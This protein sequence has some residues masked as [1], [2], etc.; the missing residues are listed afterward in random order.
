[1]SEDKTPIQPKKLPI[2]TGPAIAPE[3]YSNNHNWL[4]KPLLR[5]PKRPIVTPPK[6]KQSNA[7]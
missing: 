6:E 3:E 7:R 2:P 5:L 1:M 4:R